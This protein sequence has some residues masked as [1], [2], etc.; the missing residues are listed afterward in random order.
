MEWVGGPTSTMAC[1]D[2]A[3]LRIS[4]RHNSFRIYPEERLIGSSLN[5]SDTQSMVKQETKLLIGSIFLKNNVS[6][7]S[8][9]K[10]QIK[11]FPTVAGTSL[12]ILPQ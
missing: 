12:Q 5:P 4:R 2:T 10:C 11:V 6:R 1:M 9:T 7:L 3:I 8:T